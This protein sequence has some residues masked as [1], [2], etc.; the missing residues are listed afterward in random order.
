MK[1]LW[2]VLL[3]L[4]LTPMAWAQAAKISP[5]DEQAIKELVARYHAARDLDDPKAIGAL[6]TADADQL[7]STGEWRHGREALVQG[8]M[9]STQTRPGTRT[10]TVETVR[11]LDA[12][13]AIADARYVIEEDGGEPRR[14]WSTFLAARTA[15]GWRIAALRNMLPAK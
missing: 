11:L 7:V 3:C 1:T 10:I 14:M 4:A 2:T 15:D 6:F 5:A 13:V 8:M 12:G 9:Q